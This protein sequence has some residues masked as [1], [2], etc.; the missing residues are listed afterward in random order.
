MMGVGYWKLLTVG[1]CPN[2]IE[3]WMPRTF[4]CSYH[5]IF[6]TYYWTIYFLA[7][8]WLKWG[9]LFTC[10]YCTSVN[11]CCSRLR[12]SGTFAAVSHWSLTL[13]GCTSARGLPRM[14][15]TFVASVVMRRKLPCSSP[16]YATSFRAPVAPI[17]K[18]A[19]SFGITLISALLFG[20][21]GTF[22]I[23]RS[24][25]SRRFCAQGWHVYCA[26]Q[27]KRRIY[28]QRPWLCLRFCSLSYVLPLEQNRTIQQDIACLLAFRSRNLQ[29]SSLAGTR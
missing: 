18:A 7:F 17:P 24:R 12:P 4:K 3:I 9:L 5:Y 21:F 23:S 26:Q 20:A 16:A 28:V 2:T 27:F 6:N 19:L 29:Q 15:G 11:Y 25:V 22:A 8:A 1:G 10:A 13:H 14:R